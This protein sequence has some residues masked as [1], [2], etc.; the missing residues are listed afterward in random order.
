M[1]YHPRLDIKNLKILEKRIILGSFPTWQLSGNKATS[2]TDSLFKNDPS[3]IDAIPFFF[4][5]VQNKFWQ[6]YAFNLDTD[7]NCRNAANIKKSLQQRN[8]GI[9]DVI[10]S[11]SRKNKSALDKH[12]TQRVYNHDFLTY[13][14]RGEKV[15]ILCTSKGVMNEMLLSSKFYLFHTEIERDFNLSLQ[16]EKEFIQEIGGDHNRIINPIVS[17]L[18]IRHAG[19][20]EC[21]AIPSPGS[22]YRK[23]SNFGHES[24]NK[25]SYLHLY[26]KSAFEWF[27]RT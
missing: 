9:T 26:L 3:E 2:N 17:I 21:L 16:Y 22:P 27:T 7:L 19:T 8:I 12:L 14:E 10:L 13:P 20:I 4:G 15:K 1:E 23:L 24:G 11:C 18:N 25:D 6:W 5:S